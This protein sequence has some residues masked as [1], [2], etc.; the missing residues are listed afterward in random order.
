MEITPELRTQMINALTPEQMRGMLHF[1]SGS[2]T[3]E[4]DYVLSLTIVG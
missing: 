1:L 2:S 3:Q 4:V